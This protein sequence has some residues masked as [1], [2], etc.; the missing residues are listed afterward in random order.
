LGHCVTLGRGRSGDGAGV[1]QGFCWWL[2][3]CECFC[4][5]LVVVA[6]LPDRAPFMLPRGRSAASA[7]P[8]GGH[9]ADRCACPPASDPS[10]LRTIC[11]TLRA[12]FMRLLT[13]EHEV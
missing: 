11:L 7:R 10:Q 13:I 9:P 6:P 8:L 2:W 12:S 4:G 5:V 1:C 3:V